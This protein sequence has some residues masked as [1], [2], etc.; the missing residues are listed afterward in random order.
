MTKTARQMPELLLLPRVGPDTLA[1][2][3]DPA[4]IEHWLAR[5][6]RD[7]RERRLGL[8]RGQV[9]RGAKVGQG[10]C[11]RL[12]TAQTAVNV[13]AFA[14][15]LHFYRQQLQDVSADELLGL[16]P[17]TIE[18][19]S[20]I[21]DQGV[22]EEVDSIAIPEAG[23]QRGRIALERALLRVIQWN[24]DL[25]LVRSVVPERY[26]VESRE[27]ADKAHEYVHTKMRDILTRLSEDGVL[28]RKY[29][30]VLNQGPAKRTAFRRQREL[31]LA[32]EERK[33][34]RRAGE[35]GH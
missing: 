5:R 33:L 4:E 32:A 1:R 23:D 19:G 18:P 24:P 34:N 29:L 8:S 12:E 20:A 10:T 22:L 15:I 26:S 7:I 25:V 3:M 30:D 14:K 9:D 2:P 21:V 31:E 13:V 17:P 28:P 6:L 11:K 35:N 16:S 27:D